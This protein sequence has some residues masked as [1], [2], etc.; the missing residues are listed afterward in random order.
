[1]VYGHD[2]VS[3]TTVTMDLNNRIKKIGFEHGLKVVDAWKMVMEDPKHTK[4]E[5]WQNGAGWHMNEPSLM[6]KDIGLAI[7]GTLTPLLVD[8]FSSDIGDGIHV[9]D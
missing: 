9:S 7:I 3:L 4:P 2:W 8:D 1:M 5:Y 6:S